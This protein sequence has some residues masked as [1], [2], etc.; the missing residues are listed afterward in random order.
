MRKIRP[1]IAVVCGMFLSLLAVGHGADTPPPST[2]ADPLSILANERVRVGINLALGGAITFLAPAGSDA[3]LVNSF[4]WGRQI[5]MSFYS[6]PVPFA[7]GGKPPRKEWQGLGWNP[8]QSGDSYGHRA[9]V[10][11]QRNDGH[12]IYVRCVPM[13]WPLDDEPGECEF[14]SWIT[15][16]GPAVRVHN[17]L[18]NHRSDHTQHHARTQE[19]PAVYTNGPWHV[20]KSYTGDQPFAGQPLSVLPSVFMWKDAAPTENW[21]ALLDDTD[22][23]VG[24]WHSGVYVDGCGYAGKLDLHAG[25]KDFPTGYIAPNREEIL[26]HNITYD[27]NYVLIVGGVD[28]IRRYVYDHAE[29]PKPPVYRFEKDR[30]HWYYQNAKDGG[31]PINGELAVALGQHNP[32]LVGPPGFWHAEEAGTLR[33]VAASDAAGSGRVYWRRFGEPGFSAANS[34]PFTLPA[35]GAFHPV[36]IP[37]DNAPTYRGVITQIRI[38]PPADAKP[39]TVF[40]LREIGLVPTPHL[41]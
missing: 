31:W 14:E 38:D 4:D 25:V 3:N 32:Q 11:D 41:P 17:R 34:A 16:D 20:L 39:G 28:E 26:D 7:P 22:H 30:Q 5:Q 15:L 24:V 37:L 35:D 21:I 8:I 1:I 23:G 27:F 29:R 10:L 40:R 6:G 2:T 36:D 18:V 13:Q 33:V 19:L 9:R 12:E